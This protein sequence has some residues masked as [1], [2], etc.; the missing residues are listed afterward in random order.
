MGTDVGYLRFIF[1]FGVIGL[2]A[3]SYFIIKVGQLC[4]KKSPSIKPLLL[5]LLLVNFI[6]WF[7]VST[8]I[9][10]VFALFF[11]IDEE[12]QETALMALDYKDV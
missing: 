11:C 6:I 4:M 7:K 9:F 1:Y 8:D 2:L 10:L 5:M 3:F 12:K